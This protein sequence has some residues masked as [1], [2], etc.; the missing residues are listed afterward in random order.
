MKFFV[1]LAGTV[2]MIAAL[3][4]LAVQLSRHP[5]ILDRIMTPQAVLALCAGIGFAAAGDFCLAQGWINVVAPL[6]DRA[7]RVRLYACYI[8]TQ[9]AKY[10]P[11]NVFHFAGRTAL[12]AR[13][14]ITHDRLAAGLMAE[15]LGLCAMAG[16]LSLP[17]LLLQGPR[18]LAD[19]GLTFAAIRY[20][21]IGCVL[22]GSVM[23]A[24]LAWLVRVRPASGPGRLVLSL[25][26][27]LLTAL[28]RVGPWYVAY[29]LFQTI[30]FTIALL[31]S[32]WQF[33]MHMLPMI[34]GA[35]ALSWLAG[36]LVPGAPGGLGVREFMML[37]LLPLPR[38]IVLLAVVFWR[39]TAMLYDLAG[40]AMG[41]LMLGRMGSAEK[42]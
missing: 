20:T 8:T 21:L 27:Q 34:A 32:G 1:R 40:F 25:V 11:G 39:V 7:R 2:L 31:L 3:G 12:A 35:T 10:I 9:I 22:F 37:A 6:A 5:E 16:L 29:F 42:L 38:E 33:Q 24:G 41:S 15:P 28:P 36:Y 17:L 13:M 23:L 19:L 26:S 30:V 14:G 4:F 18:L